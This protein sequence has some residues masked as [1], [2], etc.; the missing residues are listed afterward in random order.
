[1][2]SSMILDNHI[3]LLLPAGQP[4]V[5][6]ELL[7]ACAP[8]DWREVAVVWNTGVKFLADRRALMETKI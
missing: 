6:E 1:M 5:V 3:V 4:D 8:I 2:S 7:A